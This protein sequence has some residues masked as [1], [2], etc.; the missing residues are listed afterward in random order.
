MTSS[1]PPKSQSNINCDT[2]SPLVK[3]QKPDYY[4]LTMAGKFLSI[5]AILLLF[6]ATASPTH[7]VIQSLNGQTGQQQT[8]QN[9]SNII[10]SSLNNVHALQW[11]GL[12]PISRGGTG[13]E[14]F[15]DG[16]IPFISGG[17]FAED[18]S[19]LFWD[20]TNKRLGIGTNTPAVELHVNGS[21]L[22]AP[23]DGGADDG[24]RLDPNGDIDLR[25]INFIGP[26]DHGQI[27][28]S[29][30]GKVIISPGLVIVNGYPFGIGRSLDINTSEIT[31]NQSVKFQND[32][33]TLPLLE[34]SQTYTG[35]NKFE[36]DSNSTIYVGS[37]TKSGCI[38]L[39]DSDGDGV[40]YITAN[41]GV[42]TASAT[43]PAIC[44]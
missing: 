21:I 31:D 33:G 10:I 11:A 8:F 32:S 19:N 14:S 40:T 27:Y 36:A 25:S 43:K 29:D 6:L 4:G 41:D 12:L 20:D 2:E 39:G 9:D 15:T 17:V 42:L 1:P 26:N 44:Q 18:N 7:A 13:K 5:F 24:I 38:T 37:S 30:D 34:S 3:S 23:A 28:G 35:L 16:S 22:S